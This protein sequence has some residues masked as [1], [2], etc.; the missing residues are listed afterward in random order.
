M[1]DTLRDPATIAAAIP[2]NVASPPLLAPVVPKPATGQNTDGDHIALLI[3][4][5]VAE[6][7]SEATDPAR[8]REINRLVLQLLIAPPSDH[9]N[10]SDISAESAVSMRQMLRQVTLDS[11]REEYKELSDVWKSLEAKAQVTVTIAGIFIA[12]AFTF[13][14]DL[15]TT[16]LDFYGNLC[17]GAA[18]I[19]LIPTIVLAVFVLWRRTVKSIPGGE[20]V[21]QWADISGN[22]SNENLPEMTRR[23]IDQ[24]SI[25]WK[26]TVASAKEAIVQKEECLHA[27]QI[28]LLLAIGAA[29][30]VTL[31][32][33]NV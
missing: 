15:T 33:I 6:T 18:M 7:L 28:L 31:K 19:F 29:A 13:A 8:L 10:D 24:Q 11:Y 1:D 30:I 21:E 2:S 27:A 12:A 16:R 14:K 26:D 22:T 4:T 9:S 17:L 3:R 23:F 32:L 25:V 5:L 20:T